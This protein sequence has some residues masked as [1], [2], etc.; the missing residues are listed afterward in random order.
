M[1]AGI[2]K[3]NS[4]IAVDS[5]TSKDE[6]LSAVVY[7]TGAFFAKK[8]SQSQIFM[9][10]NAKAL[11]EDGTLK[12]IL[13]ILS[14]CGDFINPPYNSY[15]IKLEFIDERSG[16]T[17][18][19]IVKTDRLTPDQKIAAI[20]SFLTAGPTLSAE[21]VLKAAERQKSFKE[22][23]ITSIS[24]ALYFIVP[25]NGQAMED[26]EVKRVFRTDEHFV[27]YCK[28]VHFIRQPETITYGEFIKTIAESDEIFNSVERVSSAKNIPF[29]GRQHIS[30][31]PANRVI[32]DLTPKNFVRY[33]KYFSRTA[34]SP[35]RDWSR[36]RFDGGVV[37]LAERM[38]K[39]DNRYRMDYTWHALADVLTEDEFT[40]FVNYAENK[41]DFGRY[42]K[43]CSPRAAAL[44]AY[45]WVKK[46][47]VGVNA[48]G[49]HVKRLS[50][51]TYAGQFDLNWRNPYATPADGSGLN[52]PRYM[53][54]IDTMDE[55]TFEMALMFS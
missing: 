55:M 10:T 3:Q 33:I 52:L 31:L 40:E 4:R 21:L 50:Q 48:L 20:A 38:A 30:T 9:L 46:G 27:E 44:L 16:E 8:K 19:A 41:S 45:A 23:N 34:T 6:T 7:N 51:Q 5:W 18:R 13:E 53:K 26:G 54:A 1:P 17:L 47:P 36:V 39:K 12:E 42:F 24:D 14:K 11:H 35:F 22:L 28:R 25:D 2:H 49:A 15:S 37:T 29:L 43:G 32:D